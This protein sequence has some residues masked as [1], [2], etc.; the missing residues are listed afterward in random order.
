MDRLC[1]TD[2]IQLWIISKFAILVYLVDKV[3]HL[4]SWHDQWCCLIQLINLTPSVRVRLPVCGSLTQSGLKMKILMKQLQSAGVSDSGLRVA[5]ATFVCSVVLLVLQWHIF[6]TTD[7]ELWLTGNSW[8][9]LY[10]NYLML[11]LLPHHCRT[12]KE[13]VLPGLVILQYP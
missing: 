12:R 6:L 13:Q 1:C 3:G 9:N 2:T 8:Y 7:C 10:G 11:H 5:F 4:V